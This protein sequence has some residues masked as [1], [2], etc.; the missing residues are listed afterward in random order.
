MGS[1]EEPFHFTGIRKGHSQKIL[2]TNDTSLYLSHII[3]LNSV[4][5]CFNSVKSIKWV[6]CLVNK[7]DSIFISYGNYV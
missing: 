1:R 7:M 3:M 2:N 4:T 5:G 6:I